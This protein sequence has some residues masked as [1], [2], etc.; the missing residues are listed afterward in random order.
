MDYDVNDIRT[1]IF[2]DE[3]KFELSNGDPENAIFYL[4]VA[5][6]RSIV[7]YVNHQWQEVLKQFNVQA[8][9]FHATKIF[10]ERRPRAALMVALTKLII[11]N[12]LICFCSKYPKDEVYEQT[13]ALSHLNSDIIDFNKK[14]FQAL[15]YFLSILNG[16]LSEGEPDLIKQ[17][18]FLY[19]DRN[20][21]GKKETERFAFPEKDY[22]FKRMVFAAKSEISPLALPDFFGYMFRKSKLF[23]NKAKFGD[24]QID[25]SELTKTSLQC[26][27]KIASA[28]LFKYLEL[29]GQT[30][31]AAINILAKSSA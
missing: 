11:D 10:K 27:Q 15:F 16:F 4:G 29:N 7:G 30:L 8:K 24:A 18:I 31:I 3:T 19:C 28:G 22:K 13:T 20:V 6:P 12:Q 26:L 17:K 5:I 2:C 14:E 21:Y 9:V 25:P 1:I 23:Q